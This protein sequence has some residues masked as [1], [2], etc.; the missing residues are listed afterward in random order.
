MA[1]FQIIMLAIFLVLKLVAGYVDFGSATLPCNIIPMSV[2]PQHDQL[3]GDLHIQYAPYSSHILAIAPSVTI[4]TNGTFLTS[5]SLHT[6]A[7]K[8]AE[9]PGLHKRG[10][11]SGI[12]IP[13]CQPCDGNGDPIK[14]SNGATCTP[15]NNK[16]C[17]NSSHDASAKTI[18]DH[19]E[20]VDSV[21]KTLHQT[22]AFKETMEELYYLSKG[23]VISCLAVHNVNHQM[24][25]TRS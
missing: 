15:A 13:T 7:T 16:V 12:P 8:T 6:R 19:F 4:G 1:N 22:T 25:L 21:Y 18:R 24:V 10:P 3:P 14:S 17:Q 9:Y 11:F 23:Q 20:M 5:W 2:I